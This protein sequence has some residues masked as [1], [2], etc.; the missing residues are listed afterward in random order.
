M[1]LTHGN[2][3]NIK[4]LLTSLTSRED[5]RSSIWNCGLH[6]NWEQPVVVGIALASH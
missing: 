4:V 6:C 5:P 3:V 2:Y 1:H